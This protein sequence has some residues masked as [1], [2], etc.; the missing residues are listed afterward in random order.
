MRKRLSALVLSLAALAVFAAVPETT[1]APLSRQIY[2]PPRLYAVEGQELNIY[3][4]NLSVFPLPGAV[5]VVA[6]VGA[7]FADRYRFIPGPKEVGTHKLR[8]EW[9]DVDGK[10]TDAWG[11]V[12][13]YRAPGVFN[14]ASYD[15][16]SAGP[17]G[18]FS[19][20][21]ADTPVNITDVS[22]YRNSAGEHICD[23][24]FNF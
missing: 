13:Y 4:A 11:V 3:F 23:D 24:L 19:S 15:L 10:L 2:L 21:N 14:P 12:I 1:S 20:D 6:K 5:E 22:K 16:V 8:L 18:K 17:D 9:R 7:Q